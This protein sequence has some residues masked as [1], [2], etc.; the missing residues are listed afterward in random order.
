M[1][2]V[3]PNL[4]CGEARR[5][6][7]SAQ[8]SAT[9]EQQRHRPNSAQPEGRRVFLAPAALRAP[10]RPLAGMLVARAL[11]VPKIPRRERYRIY[12]HDH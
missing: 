5:G 6:S 11:P 9:E 12:A 1:A 10:Y 7:I 8:A 4:A 3:A 2:F